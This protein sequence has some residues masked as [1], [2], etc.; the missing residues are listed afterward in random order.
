MIRLSILIVLAS[1]GIAFARD[2]TWLLCRGTGEHGTG[3]D[4]QRTHVV[5]SL[6]EH[7]AA[8]GTDRDVAITLIYG[9][10]V[11]KGTVASSAGTGKAEAV[12]LS[13]LE[14]KRAVVFTGTSALAQDMHAITFAGSIDWTFGAANKLVPF[15]AKL[16]CDELDDQA[17]GH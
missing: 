7:R 16:T 12:K 11:I 8:N 9:D 10:H 3:A 6:H 15:S 2:S 13:T 14:G 17:I 4:K 1:S 5:A